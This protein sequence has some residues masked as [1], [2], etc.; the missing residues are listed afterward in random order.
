MVQE[1]GRLLNVGK[2]RVWR[3]GGGDYG[4]ASKGPGVHMLGKSLNP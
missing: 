4:D 2:C 1:L 3:G